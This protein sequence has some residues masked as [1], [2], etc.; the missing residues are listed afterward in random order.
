[1]STRPSPPAWLGGPPQRRRDF[2]SWPV[3]DA[4][5]EDGL[6]AVLRSGKWWRFSYGEGVEL[7]EPPPGQA[8]SQVAEFQ[9]AFA[10]AHGVRYGIACAN[11]TAALE[12]ALKALGIGPGDEVIVPAYTYVATATAVLM[13]NAVPIFADIEPDTFNLSPAAVEAA[14]TGRTRAIIPVHFGGQAADMDRLLALARPHGIAV[15]EDAAHAHGASY[16]GAPCGSLGTAGTFS[17]QASKNMTAGEGGLITTSDAALAARC[18]SYLWAGREPGRPWYEHYRL[19]WN[20]RLTEFQGAI[21]LP[22]LERLADQNSRRTANA[23]YLSRGLAAIPGIQ[24]LARRPYAD[25]LSYHLYLFRLDA[26]AFGLDR[27]TFLSALNAE[28]IPCQGGYTHP[29]YR[30]P[31]FL[32]RNFYPRG[33]PFTCGHYPRAINYG[34]FAALCP[35]AERACQEAVWLEHRLLLGEKEDMDDIIASVQKIHAHR[36]ALARAGQGGRP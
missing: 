19:G 31:M 32:E 6:L 18:E 24:P 36:S 14:L 20:Y 13:M 33:C 9:A 17:F 28:G 23:E 16:R 29:L 7:R 35:A 30:N 4:R 22:Q 8:R 12:I 5:E 26:A 2:P 1:M 3:F 10:R 11:G 25:R 27:Q 34:D 21:L 15:V